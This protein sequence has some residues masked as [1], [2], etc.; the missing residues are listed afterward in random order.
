L[1]EIFHPVENDGLF[2]KKGKTPRF[3]HENPLQFLDGLLKLP[4]LF[5]SPGHLEDQVRPG[6]PEKGLVKTV[7]RLLRG[8]LF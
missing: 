1:I 4:H 7:Q 3:D 8:M 2:F 6:V 5:E